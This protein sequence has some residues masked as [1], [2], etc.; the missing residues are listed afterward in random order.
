MQRLLWMMRE[1]SGSNAWTAG[2][3]IGEIVS[4]TPKPLE[5]IAPIV[6]SF[7]DEPILRP[8]ALWSLYRI[9]SVR[10]DLVAEFGPVAEEYLDDPSPLVR[11]LAVLALAR[12]G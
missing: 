6:V 11:G 10:P 4:R 8:G 5:D 12:S 9:G 1:E 3:I 7:H 2:Q